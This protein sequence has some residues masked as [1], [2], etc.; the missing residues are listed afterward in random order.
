MSENS[1][2]VSSDDV[3]PQHHLLHPLTGAEHSLVTLVEDQVDGLIESLQ[4]ALRTRQ[5][6]L[7]SESQSQ[8]SQKVRELEDLTMNVI[9][10]SNTDVSL[11]SDEAA[12]RSNQL[13]LYQLLFLSPRKTIFKSSESIELQLE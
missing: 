1:H 3:K 10:A 5:D 11:V 7:D 4:S 9:N 12:V 6:Q 2:V 13:Q 8:Q